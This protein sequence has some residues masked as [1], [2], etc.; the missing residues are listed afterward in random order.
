MATANRMDRRRW[1][2][3]ASAGMVVVTLPGLA[4]CGGQGDEDG[5]DAGGAGGTGATGGT[6]GSAPTEAVA[7]AL[8][9][10]IAS[11]LSLA[12]G[13]GGFD[14][15]ALA[16]ALARQ[17]AWVR[18]GV[19]EA[20]QSVWAR[21]A[22]GQW[23]IVPNATRPAASA[24]ATGQSKAAAAAPGVR[25]ERTGAEPS[26]GSSGGGRARALAGGTELPSLLVARGFRLLDMW[27][28]MPLH[29]VLHTTL[30][31]VD[32]NTLPG[33]RKIA[34]GRGFDVVHL[35]REYY[36]PVSTVAGLKAVAD[37]GVFFVNT[38]GGTGTDDNAQISAIATNSTRYRF[39]GMGERVSDPGFD[40]DLDA[41]RLVHM[42]VP[43]LSSPALQYRAVLG[44]TPAFARFYNWSFP[45]S[46]IGFFNVIG[47]NIVPDW[48]NMLQ[49]QGLSTLITW[50]TSVSLPRM[51][52]AAEDFF[53][54]TLATNRLDGDVG[55]ALAKQPRLR[56]Y[57]NGETLEFLQERGVFGADDLVYLPQHNPA[58]FVNVLTPTIDYLLV[59][60]DRGELQM[61]GQ[62]G[63]QRSG[64]VVHDG[65]ARAFQ[66][67][68]LIDA[69]DPLQNG[70]KLT[71]NGWG[72]DFIR[73]MAPSDGGLVQVVNDGRWSNAAQLTY[74]NV[75]VTIRNT[76]TGGPTIDLTVNLRFRAD[77]RGF[78]LRPDQS[79]AGQIPEIAIT[80]MSYT[81]SQW[82][83]SGSAS[84]T[85]G[86]TTTRIE[87]GGS[88][89][90]SS[91]GGF[92]RFAGRLSVAG[93]KLEGAISVVVPGLRVRTTVSSD[94][95]IVSDETVTGGS[96]G[97]PVGPAAKLMFSFDEHW[98]LRP[99]GA[100]DSAP[101]TLLGERT[102]EAVMSWPGAEA[103]VPPEN[104][105]G[106]V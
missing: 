47:T 14:A 93:R 105:Y 12:D 5:G 13:Q 76:V 59:D 32:A 98:N 52:A 104:D 88:G 17:P 66:E 54:L 44:I 67:P 42:V 20:D 21:L 18:T 62:F 33:I 75:P 83:G 51:L 103:S 78:R 40:D 69:A 25:R 85:Q 102:V 77:V 41:G 80:G 70:D 81:S 4:G 71:I 57:G 9:S 65:G 16:S 50:A 94:G 86:T 61:V 63:S 34:A 79:I 36:F 38:F 10:A 84:E 91:V 3:M 1:L 39:N 90:V 53:H 96:G 74:W 95:K 48:H 35:E 101:Y 60:E 43:V 6:G 28:P 58:D 19:S 30:N 87:W 89:S 68:L 97:F 15:A 64:S 106:G 2:G 99:G 7:L 24:S 29:E 31:W 11:M 27:G 82:T 37:D 92:V 46:S 56:N 49:A 23:L 22:N 72:G 26:N 100:Q 73:C 45:R 55:R 8:E